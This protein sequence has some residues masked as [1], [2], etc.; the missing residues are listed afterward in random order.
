[1]GPMEY[2]NFRRW[3]MV[4][5]VLG[6]LAGATWLPAQIVQI[7]GEVTAVRGDFAG[8]FDLGAPVAVSVDLRLPMEDWIPEDDRVGLFTGR[9]IALRVAGQAC[10]VDSWPS[11]VMITRSGWGPFA[12][13][14]VGA[15][16]PAIDSPRVVTLALVGD[17]PWVGSDTAFP[18]GIAMECFT[19]HE[20]CYWAPEGTIEWTINGYS[21]ETDAAAPVPEPATYGLAAAALLVGLVAGRRWRR[22]GRRVEG[23]MVR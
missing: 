3:L 4:A 15:S 19:Y 2:L 23:D 11:E 8:V 6:L 22:A 17:L 5:A 16:W 1:M 20:G 12:G 13:L 10:A 9:R 21:V 7:T 14:N 18:G